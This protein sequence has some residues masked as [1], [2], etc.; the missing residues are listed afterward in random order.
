MTKRTNPLAN[1]SVAAPCPADWEQMVGNEQVRFC[2]QCNLNVYNLSGM[3]RTDAE[4]LIAQ[5]EGRLCVRYY[6]RADGT[7][8]T[9]NCPIGLRALHQRL[10]RTA[11]GVAAMVLS[12]LAGLF[13]FIGL[14]ESPV[15][16]DYVQGQLVA[17]PR[18]LKK[19]LPEIKELPEMKGT[20]N[21]PHGVTTGELLVYPPPLNNALRAKARRHR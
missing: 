14:R 13:A 10:R 20:L 7:I 11:S 9:K 8:L 5:N 12:F 19:E 17:P 6:R 21:E 16:S 1:V 3:K 18:P 2:S 15:K 4:R